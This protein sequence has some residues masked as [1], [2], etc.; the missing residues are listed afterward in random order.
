MMTQVVDCDF[1]DLA[2]GM[3]LTVT[4]RPLGD[5]LQMAVFRPT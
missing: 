5:D 1:G 4:F 3:A 2:V